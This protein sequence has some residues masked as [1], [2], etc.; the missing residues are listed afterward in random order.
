MITIFGY[1]APQTDTEA[2]NAMQTAW[3]D[4]NKREMEQT[5]FITIQSEEEIQKTWDGFIHTHHY[6]ICDDFYNS[7]IANHHRR[8]GEAWINQYLDAKFIDYNPILQ[9]VTHKELWNWFEKFKGPE[10]NA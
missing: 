2:I 7:W 3:G 10:T 8:T 1:S 4:K 9:N 6:E 5:A